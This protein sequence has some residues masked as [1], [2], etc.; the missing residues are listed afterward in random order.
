M[1][2]SSNHSNHFNQKQR[3][4][5][6]L[7]AFSVQLTIIVGMSMEVETDRAL[8]AGTSPPWGRWR[9]EPRCTPWGGGWGHAKLACPTTTRKL[10]TRF[11]LICND[12]CVILSCWKK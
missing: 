11:D 1:K 6:L 4:I 3:D 10:S 8:V 7:A 5:P 9:D 12:Q 2:R